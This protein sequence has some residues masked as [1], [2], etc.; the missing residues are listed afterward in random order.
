MIDLEGKVADIKVGYSRLQ[1]INE[2]RAYLVH[3]SEL[4]LPLFLAHVK[5]NF[6]FFGFTFTTAVVS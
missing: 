2:L 6:L 3:L 1:N 4:F 5:R